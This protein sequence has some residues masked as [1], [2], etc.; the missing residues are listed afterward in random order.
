MCNIN[1]VYK[2]ICSCVQILIGL[3]GLLF[4]DDLEAIFSAYR[5]CLT[6]AATVAYAV[7][8]ANI[9]VA[10]KLYFGI[11]ALSF[12]TLSYLLLEWDIFKTDHAVKIENGSNVDVDGKN[13]T[14]ED[15]DGSND[16]DEVLMTYIEKETSI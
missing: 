8:T 12:A 1:F 16:E 9:C 15:V 6:G 2:F 3:L 11:I 5:F 10:Y 13:G 14:K 7:G 4:P